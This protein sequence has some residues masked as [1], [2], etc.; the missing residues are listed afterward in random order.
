M[1]D[2]AP[3]APLASHRPLPRPARAVRIY[4][5]RMTPEEER[6]SDLLDVALRDEIEL[7]SDLVVAA[8][9]SPRHFTPAE[10]DELLGIGEDACADATTGP[11]SP[12]TAEASLPGI[13]DAPGVVVGD[14]AAQSGD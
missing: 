8:S 11:D 6:S 13:P 3:P 12:A 10:V 5:G 1:V 9:G 4:S 7:V 2:V 14:V